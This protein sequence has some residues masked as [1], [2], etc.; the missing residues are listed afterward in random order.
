MKINNA[1]LHVFDFVS[2]VNAFAQEELDLSNK[3]TKGYVTKQARRALNNIDNKRGEFASDSLFAEE[4]RKYFRGQREFAD[5]SVQV[6]EYIV[7]ELSRMEKTESTDLLVI[8]FEGDAESTVRDMNE[9]EAAAAYEARGK[10]YF[11][12]LL[13]ESRQAFMHEVGHGESGAVRNG[14]ARHHAIL[15]NPSQKVQSYAVIESRTLNVL[16]CDKERTIAG[17]QRWL[18]PD[19]LLQCSMGASG[20]ETIDAVT[21]IVGEVAGQYGANA[22]MAVSKAKAYVSENADESDD[23]YPEELGREVFGDDADLQKRFSEAVAEEELPNRVVVEKAVAKRVAKTHK[24]RTDTGIDI[25]FPAEYGKNPDFIQFVSG[26]D[27]LLS[28]ELKNIGSIENR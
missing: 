19:G 7:G 6:A 26:S 8:D 23:V 3:N 14:I 5:L 24:I 25:S 27:G 17:D 1:I 11:A 9:E 28:I 2:C 10:R 15:P 4:L 22:A 21:R 18:I 13:L 12:F 20:K 16:F